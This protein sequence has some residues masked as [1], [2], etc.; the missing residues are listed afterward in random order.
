MYLQVFIR[1]L[2]L[3]YRL[4]IIVEFCS[5]NSNWTRWWIVLLKESEI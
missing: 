3:V 2:S 1:I 5:R 4:F